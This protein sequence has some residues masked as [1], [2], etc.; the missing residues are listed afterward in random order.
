VGALGITA[1][2]SWFVFA[3]AVLVVLALRCAAAGWRMPSVSLVIPSATLVNG[4]FFHILPTIV[5]GQVSPGV[6][7]A[8]LLYLPFSSWA[9][10]GARRDGVPISAIARGVVGGTAM[11]LSIVV[12]M[13]W[14]S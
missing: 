4:L 5:M 10:V 7:T 9:L 12:V 11:M 1:P 14:L 8:T 2:T 3:N 6:Y 13:R